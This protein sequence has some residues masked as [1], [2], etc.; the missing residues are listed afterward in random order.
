MSS[1]KRYT[2][3]DLSSA[4]ELYLGGTRLREV[5]QRYPMVPSRTITHRAQKVVAGLPVKHPG[6]QPILG[7]LETDL[8]GF[9]VAMQVKGHPVTRD[10]ILLKGN[11]M[12]KV[13]QK[14]QL[15]SDQHSPRRPFKTLKRG[16]VNRFLKRFPI[17]TVPF[18]TVC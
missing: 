13:L 6:P 10:T 2:A 14:K 3:E 16:W 18:L 8:K 9:I 12:Y 4:V 1:R 11:K 15:D 17:L 7:D 5:T